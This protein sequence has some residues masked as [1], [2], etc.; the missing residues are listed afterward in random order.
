VLDS[1]PVLAL[2]AQAGVRRLA[3]M[4]D[5]VH[6][7]DALSLLRLLPDDSI[8]CC[9]SSPPY[10]QLRDYNAPGQ[11]GMEDTL[12]AFIEA[13]VGLYR[14][15]R[16]VLKP[17]GTCFV[18]MGDTYSADRGYQV[19]DNKHKD[20]GNSFGRDSKAIG[21]AP[22]QRCMIP[23]RLA[24][25][26]QDE[27]WWVRDEIIWHKLNPMPA[28]YTDRTTYAHEMIYM[29]TKRPTY[30]Y[31]QEA[32]REP[33]RDWGSRDRS[34]MRGGT[35]DPKLKHHGL[36]DGDFA[37]IG[38]NA[39][40][41]WA[42]ATEPSKYDHYAAFPS[43]L[44]RRCIKAGCPATVCAVC[45]KPYERQ[46]EI[47]YT[48]ASKSRGKSGN[49]TFLQAGAGNKAGGW[50]DY[51]SMDKHVTT[52]GFA[53]SCDCH[54]ATK[55]GVVLD[56]FMGSGTVALV[57]RQLGRHFIGSDLNAAYVALCRERLRQPFEAHYIQRETKLPEDKAD[58]QL[59][60]FQRL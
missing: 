22:K 2:P 12:Q 49:G 13:L 37:A 3:D 20:V 56:P 47:A 35:T 21:L 10:W 38:R 8:D 15:V 17:T 34:A 33:A 9:V 31:D 51:P 14:E 50:N 36:A 60:L 39:R 44:P 1:G 45:G 25:A 42:F 28:S 18:N 57:A 4:L 11:I 41:V 52:L 6:H 53:P 48:P 46:T 54:A 24:I 43:E 58:G 7:M 30:W 29:L 55:P 5:Q 23:A 16:R 32:I 40:S 19:A 59:A 27:G 26:L